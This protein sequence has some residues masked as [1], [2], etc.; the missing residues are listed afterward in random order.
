M[1]RVLPSCFFLLSNLVPATA[2]AELLAVNATDAYF[3]SAADRIITSETCG[4][5]SQIGAMRVVPHS[6]EVHGTNDWWF[7][8]EARQCAA[9]GCVH[10]GSR[11]DAYWCWA[12]P[13]EE[14]K[15]RLLCECEQCPCDAGLGGFKCS[16]CLADSAC[17][18]DGQCLTSGLISREWNQQFTCDFTKSFMESSSY[19]LFWGGGY[20]HPQAFAQ[21]RPWES[22]VHIT[23]LDNLCAKRQPVMFQC[24]CTDC[25][26]HVDELD[27]FTE[28]VTGTCKDGGLPSPCVRCNTC[29]CTY[30]DDSPLPADTRVIFDVVSQGILMGCEDKGNSNGHCFA[31]LDDL[32]IMI[33]FDCV[34][35]AC[36]PANTTIT[37][38]TLVVSG[39]LFGGWAT[40]AM[41]L[42]VVL[43]KS[44]ACVLL[45][46]TLRRI[47]Q[48]RLASAAVINAP[49][50]ILS[51]YAAAQSGMLDLGNPRHQEVFLSLS[52]SGVTC[53][54]NEITILKDM[55]GTVKSLSERRG[56]L[57][58]MIG[59]SGSGKTTLLDVLSGNTSCGD[60]G[61]VRINGQELDAASRRRSISYIQ[62]G[63]FLSATQTVRET[64]EF[65]AA[66]RLRALS[67]SERAG[68]VAWALK[69]LRLDSIADSRI[70]DAYRRGISG[71]ERR[72]VS[73]GV[74]LVI[75]PAVM[76]LDEPTTGL[77]A[78]SAL[79]LG[80]ILSSLADDD[81]LIVCSMHQPRRELI[82]LFDTIVDLGKLGSQVQAASAFR[83]PGPVVVGKTTSDAAGNSADSK[84]VQEKQYPRSHV[85]KV[86][87]EA[88]RTAA[89]ASPASMPI[90][91]LLLWQRG[92][93]EASRERHGLVAATV[94]SVIGLSLGLLYFNLSNGIQGVQNRFGSIFFTQLFFAY[95]GLE[96]CTRWYLDRER[97]TR[98]RSSCYY[99]AGSYYFAKASAYIWWYCLIIPL[100]F[101]MASYFLIGYRT[102]GVSKP[103]LFFLCTAGTVASSSGVCLICLSTSSTFAPG[104][105]VSAVSIT[106]LLMFAGVLQRR[107]AIP[108]ALRWLVDVS[109]FAH[110]YAAMISSEL[111]GLTT[112]IDAPGQEPVEVQ[113]D[114]WLSQF[115]FNPDSI[116]L[117]SQVLILVSTVLWFLAFVP[118][119][120]EWYRAKPQLP[121]CAPKSQ[122]LTADIASEIIG[123]DPSSDQ[124][125]DKAPGPLI[126]KELQATL[127]N[128]TSLYS[129]P[130]AKAST[131]D[132]A[133]N[134][135]ESLSGIAH[136][137]RPL[138]I[139][140]PSGCGKTTLLSRLAGEET[141]TQFSGSVQLGR[142]AVREW[143][144]RKI[145]GYVHQ[146]DALHPELT[147]QEAV[148]FAASLRL[149]G[150]PAKHRAKR[151]SWT[152][153]RLGLQGV[154]RSRV[155]GEKRRGISG[156]ER[157]RTAVAVELVAAR[158]VLVLDEPTSGL[159]HAGALALAKLLAEIAAAGCVVVATL[160]QPDDDLLVHFPDALVLGPGGRV[161]YFGPTNSI[162]DHASIARTLM[163]TASASSDSIISRSASGADLIMDRICSPDAELVYEDYAKSTVRQQLKRELSSIPTEEGQK[164]STQELPP[165]IPQLREL[166]LREARVALRDRSLAPYHYGSA[167][168]AGL[169]LG[170]TYFQMG[171]NVAGVLSRIGLFFVVQ[172]IISM[173]ALQGLMAWRE[174][175]TTFVRERS[176]G[177]YSTG[178][179]VFAKA[180]VDALLLRVGP[181]ILLC[182][183][184]YF[185]SGLRSGGEAACC[186]A[187]CL[188]SMASSAFC[189][190][191]GAL[192]PRSASVL[193]VAV[194]LILLFL[195]FGGV[196]LRSGSAI[197]FLSYF[198]A[199]Y[200]WLVANEFRGLIFKSDF[201]DVA[202]E[203][204]DISGEEWMRLLN[205]Q[206]LGAG[207]Q[208]CRLLGWTVFYVLAAW[209]ALDL[210]VCFSSCWAS[211]RR[212]AAA[213][214]IRP[215]VSESGGV[216]PAPMVLPA[217]V[218]ED[219]DASSCVS[220]S[221]ETRQEVALEV[222]PAQ[223]SQAI[224]NEVPSPTSVVMR[225]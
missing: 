140:G 120:R 144:L 40:T 121:A 130:D 145:V 215:P 66:L 75:S 171:T 126:W 131:T 184:V 76:I 59:P 192:A 56:N 26:Q 169:L 9:S 186:L 191:L 80:K 183:C 162:R 45:S 10:D 92:L 23:F 129:M 87:A 119:W 79:A 42:L 224:V 29:S 117:N 180:A 11:G 60:T 165:I 24:I 109:P 168:A 164:L 68:R 81:R 199:S 51:A 107:D 20:A 195:L 16:T 160:H 156:G 202:A 43:F 22:S 83:A 17:G 6:F 207:Y 177:Y 128:G 203:I 113:G 212:A 217:T 223:E 150:V 220:P 170:F 146:D 134:A 105:S 225:L 35:G 118:V 95:F 65:S 93:T 71:G 39:N 214:P 89:G 8:Q 98:E 27:S 209:L 194:L 161:A 61:T 221:W 159:D 178:A 67:S 57:A 210:K 196:L 205:I 137:G 54:R 123:A 18:A 106:V 143:E 176:A 47:R 163:S 90:Q 15:Q 32:P 116:A 206:Q 5:D 133:I 173:Q 179:F 208:A 48:K 136:V 21:W 13:G 72:R 82:D 19:T 91:V 50:P 152:L 201:E 74:E 96:A 187:F 132:G 124:Q 12:D 182:L 62:Q 175:Y 141:A 193:P 189:L 103:L 219:D 122:K 4:E 28:E 52:W 148:S 154:A 99:S 102:E 112:V 198:H 69:K 218:Q 85:T 78:S 55:A 7:E 94:V 46:I 25:T 185:L 139:L 115:N 34:I 127:P 213:S 135:V 181:S 70:G 100:L 153:Q 38:S 77:D 149:P 33:D 64:L 41:L 84:D 37:Q 142:A 158:G 114:L 3:R 222:P 151:V 147:V 167:L 216:L 197:V 31:V 108:L 88:G 157:R 125:L 110:S 14:S 200:N 73:I 49:G 111:K 63:S 30:T 97:F 53:I 104:M 172:C 138:A 166:L 188:A 155:G 44:S 58:A 86:L 36:V 101:T 2:L 190:F 174:C 1:L 204:R 211:R